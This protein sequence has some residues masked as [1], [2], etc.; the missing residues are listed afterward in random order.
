MSAPADTKSKQI[1]EKN[2]KK[3]IPEFGVESCVLHHSIY[4]LL[5]IVGLTHHWVVVTVDRARRVAVGCRLV[6]GV[7]QYVEV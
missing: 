4:A 2:P 3:Q 6:T 7:V 1:P 5:F